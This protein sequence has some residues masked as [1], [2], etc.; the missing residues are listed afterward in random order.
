MGA[1]RNSSVFHRVVCAWAA[2]AIAAGGCRTPG[3]TT[4]AKPTPLDPNAPAAVAAGASTGRPQIP[5]DTA[6][7]ASAVTFRTGNARVTAAKAEI[8]TLAE[9]ET[10]A[11]H[12]RMEPLPVLDNSKAPAL[13]PPSPPP[14]RSGA[15]QPIAFAVPT[16]KPVSDAPVAPSRAKVPLSRP[17]I[18]PVGELRAE[19]TVRVRFSEPMVAIAA[20]GTPAIAPATITPAVAGTWRWI[21]TRVAAFASAGARFPAAT[22]YT[23]TVRA[24]TKSLAGATLRE[25]ATSTFS[26]PPIM[27]TGTFPTTMLR[28]DSPVL[29]RFDQDFDPAQ[30]QPLLRVTDR[31]GKPTFAH[32]VITLDEAMKRWP[33]NPSIRFPLSD[34]DRDAMIGKRHVVIAPKTAWPAG[35]PMQVVLG[36]N[37]PSREGPRR[38]QVE[39]ATTFEVAPAFTVSGIRCTSDYQ[40]RRFNITCPANGWMSVE[41]SNSIL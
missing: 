11:L 39:T 34:K 3:P 20:V 17:Q 24:G 9:R 14:A 27:V 5:I 2:V 23:V 30:I 35:R 38:S 6:A 8:T 19:S 18:S 4:I 36:K 28:P 26:T 29:V 21:D 32:E 16:G 15:V 10:A 33:K 12:A 13:R 40:I 41:L 22:E 7:T 37:A 25:D 31:T 1:M